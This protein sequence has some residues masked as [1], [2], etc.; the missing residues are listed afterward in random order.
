MDCFKLPESK[1]KN[2]FVIM[3]ICGTSKWVEGRAIATA[4]SQDTS[5][6]LFDQIICRY[7]CPQIIRSDN[8]PEF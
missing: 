5:D 7:G 8:G 1:Y 3:S 6:F 4:N 2:N